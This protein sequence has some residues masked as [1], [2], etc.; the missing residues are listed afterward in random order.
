MQQDYPAFETIIT[1]EYRLFKEY[2][3]HSID[4]V[5]I[6]VST[7]HDGKIYSEKTVNDIKLQANFDVLY[8]IKQMK[9]NIKETLKPYIS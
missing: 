4:I 5:T 7:M 9:N 6:I 2:D 3:R 1:E 8:R